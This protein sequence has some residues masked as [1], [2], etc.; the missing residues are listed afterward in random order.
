M[1]PGLDIATAEALD[2]EHSPSE[3]FSSTSSDFSPWVPPDLENP[4]AADSD[5][6]ESEQAGTGS[7]SDTSPVG[8][9]KPPRT[10]IRDN[11][12]EGPLPPPRRAID[13]PRGGRRSWSPMLGALVA[14]LASTIILHITPHWDAFSLGRNSDNEGIQNAVS[15]YV[16]TQHVTLA[17]DDQISSIIDLYTPFLCP[18]TPLLKLGT[19]TLGLPDELTGTRRARLGGPEDT[20]E[21]WNLALTRK[22]VTEICFSPLMDGSDL[23]SE[24]AQVCTALQKRLSSAREKQADVAHSLA[25]PHTIV[26]WLHQVHFKFLGLFSAL[27]GMSAEPEVAA[28]SAKQRTADA[29]CRHMAEGGPWHS[30]NKKIRGQLLL[31]RQDCVS[32][33]E[34]L[35]VL[36]LH[37]DQAVVDPGPE[38]HDSELSSAVGLFVPK[39][40]PIAHIESMIS[41]IDTC[42]A[43]LDAVD[44]GLLQLRTLI[45]TTA[46]TGWEIEELING[47]PVRVLFGLPAPQAILSSVIGRLGKMMADASELQEMWLLSKKAP[48]A[49]E[50]RTEGV[51]VA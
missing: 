46:S 29:L 31:L 43:A 51:Q 5:D 26:L 24:P 36:Y 13:S 32:I 50:Q 28:G 39:P 6:P 27:Q 16:T 25:S 19:G 7:S 14:I 11:Y 15:L 1:T 42:I 48:S 38:L 20:M 18:D 17:V 4:V 12:T 22:R 3:A 49:N 10:S 45:A 37:H 35:G 21:A 47:A 34:N 33:A 23:H 9:I 44:N 2:L 41:A 8:A 40:I 30:I